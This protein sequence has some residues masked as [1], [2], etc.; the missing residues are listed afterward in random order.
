MPTKE[1]LAIRNRVLLT[2][3]ATMGWLVLVLCWMAF[4][5]SH[6]PFIQNLA[7]LGISA[8]LTAAIIGAMWVV[9]LG[10]MPVA[11]ILTTLGWLSFA[12]WW[13]GF[14]SSRHTVLE[15]GVVLTLSLLACG[16]A[17]VALWRRGR[18]DVCC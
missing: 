8:L 13:I 11:T 6:Y 12:L 14:A 18:P 4:A 3:L 2:V 1:V 7:S 15:N 5:W 9:D 17:V 10:F 16:G